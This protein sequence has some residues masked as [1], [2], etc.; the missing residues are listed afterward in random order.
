[1]DKNQAKELLEKIASVKKSFASLSPKTD[2]MFRGENNREALRTLAKTLLLAAGGGAA[3]R[4]LSGLSGILANDPEPVPSRTVDMPLIYGRKKEK[5]ANSKLRSPYYIPGMLLGAPLAAYGGWKAVDSVLDRQ[6]RLKTEEELEEAK[7][8]YEEA[9]LS[10]YKRGEDKVS[11]DELLD[12]VFSV[13]KSASVQ[14][15]MDTAKGL[16]L[17]YA[18]ATAPLGY[19]V[20]NNAMK[21][22]SKRKILEKAMRERARI[23]AQKQP[24]ELYAIPEPRDIEENE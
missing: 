10:S 18:L 6:R 12:S 24:A 3:V 1:M 5:T 13:Y 2:E 4:G 11:N 15:W 21:K 9:V 16:G 17:T 14:D 22:K 19:L 7:K 20:V 8:K 23:Q